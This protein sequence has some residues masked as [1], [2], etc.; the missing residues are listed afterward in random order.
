MT[1]IIACCQNEFSQMSDKGLKIDHN[2]I[3]KYK[4][5]FTGEFNGLHGALQVCAYYPL[6]VVLVILAIFVGVL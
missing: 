6:F 1:A 4:I 2:V 3:Y 5:I